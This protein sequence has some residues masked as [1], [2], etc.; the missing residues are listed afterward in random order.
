[1]EIGFPEGKVI[2]IAIKVIEKNYLKN[3]REDILKDFAGRTIGWENASSPVVEGKLVYVVGGGAGTIKGGRHLVY[4][5]GTPLT[6]LHVTLLDK[7]GVPVDKLG[8]S[9]GTFRELSELSSAV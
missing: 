1:M 3:K 4:P 8:D 6:N 7:V 2:G 9:T 5:E